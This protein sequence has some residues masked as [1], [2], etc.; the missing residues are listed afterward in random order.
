M[1]KPIDDIARIIAQV[2]QAA[3]QRGWNAALEHVVNVAR[4]PIPPEQ[5][6]ALPLQLANG[7]HATGEADAPLTMIQMVSDTIVQHPGLRG[8]DIVSAVHK[9]MP[10]KE[11]KSID[12][13]ARTAIM[14]LKKRRKIE[15]VSGKWYPSGYTGVFDIDINSDAEGHR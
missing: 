2:E 14:R 4:K 13:T 15:S 5:Q 10:D 1:V 3:Y 7:T 11:K 9:L 8:A 6:Q 12:R